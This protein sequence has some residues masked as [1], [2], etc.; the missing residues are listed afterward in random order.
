[1]NEATVVNVIVAAD[2]PSALTLLEKAKAD[3]LVTEV[4]A[5]GSSVVGW[6][7]NGSRIVGSASVD[8]RLGVIRGWVQRPFPGDLGSLFEPR[9]AIEAILRRSAEPTKS[10]AG[11]Q[12]RFVAVVETQGPAVVVTDPQGAGEAF[13]TTVEDGTHVAATSISVLRQLLGALDLDRSNEDILLKFGFIPAPNTVAAGVERQPKGTARPLG[14]PPVAIAAPQIDARPAPD[15]LDEAVEGLDHHL[16]S[17]VESLL[18][19]DDTIAILLGGFDSALIASAA[20]RTGRRVETYSFCYDDD[21]YNQAFAEEVAAL[22]GGQHHWVRMDADRLAE[23]MR[24]FGTWFNAPTNWPIYTLQ[25]VLVASQITA[26]GLEVAFSGDGC[27]NLFQGYPLTYRRGQIVEA[28]ARLPDTALQVLRRGLSFGRLDFLGRPLTVARGV[29]DNALR[30]TPEARGYIS[31]RVMDDNAIR[32]LR[33][34]A[35]TDLIDA[36]R[37]AVEAAA[38][39][40]GRTVNELSYLGKKLLTPSAIKLTASADVAGLPIV[41]PYQ[42]PAMAAYAGS[43]GDD[44]LRPPDGGSGIGKFALVE[45]A[46]RLGYLPHHII[47]QPKMAAA[48]VPLHAWYSGA[49]RPVLEEHLSQLPFPVSTT[50]R[51]VLFS[52]PAGERAY[53]SLIG[54]ETNNIANLHHDLSLL[55]TYGAFSGVMR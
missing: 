12:G 51:D 10:F 27:D 39:H 40:S 55:A 8:Q 24:H 47:H 53:A 42:V 28:A 11:V 49:M 2:G 6:S 3:A 22:C 4:A 31:F 37:Y 20:A 48:D 23:A 18:P 38:A 1:M 33:A 34:A 16:R 21:R 45:M 35:P 41:S 36:E 15:T 17:A 43:L 54:R 7:G 5:V 13:H 25:T 32:S 9:A 46:E 19:D 44:L 14:A 52:E 29:V 50:A 26:D 30:P